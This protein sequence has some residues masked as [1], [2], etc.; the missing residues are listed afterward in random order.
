MNQK[1]PIYR[2]LS[3]LQPLFKKVE[4]QVEKQKKHFE[5]LKKFTLDLEGSEHLKR[6]SALQQDLSFIA[7]ELKLESPYLSE[8]MKETL[9]KV[10]LLK[11][12]EL[13]AY[14]FNLQLAALVGGKRTRERFLASESPFWKNLTHFYEFGPLTEEPFRQAF[15]EKYKSAL[16]T[17]SL[18]RE[19]K[20]DFLEAS[21]E[22]FKSIISCL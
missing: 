14:S 9:D 5:I 19:E 6:E 3:H 20:D 21:K 15:Y 11:P 7:R 1:K 12:H 17:L 18:S 22:V 10:E 16:N 2:Y 8:K 4:K 13:L